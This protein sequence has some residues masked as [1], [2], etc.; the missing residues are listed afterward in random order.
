[1]SESL[2]SKLMSYVTDLNRFKICK[3][4]LTIFLKD[5]N[6]CKIEDHELFEI[7]LGK[8]TFVKYWNYIVDIIISR[9]ITDTDIS[10]MQDDNKDFL[11]LMVLHVLF[12]IDIV[13]YE[14]F[15]DKFKN[16]LIDDLKMVSRIGHVLFNNNNTNEVFS[17]EL[18]FK[19][20]VLRTHLNVD[21]IDKFKRID[22]FAEYV[23][24]NRC[25]NLN[26]KDKNMLSELICEKYCNIHTYDFEK[27]LGYSFLDKYSTIK[28]IF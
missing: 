15:L 1:M 3:R 16:E 23:F 21:S 8:R 4:S 12:E 10:H 18:K 19:H 6:E 9:C 25:L 7:T 2:Q 24:E 13:N 27:V 28:V 22:D 17:Y 11:A 26:Q 14:I 20:G 5:F